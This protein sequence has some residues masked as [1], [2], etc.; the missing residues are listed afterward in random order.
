MALRLIVLTASEGEPASVLLKGRTAKIGRAVGCDVRLPDPSVSAHH[1]T[2]RRRGDNY[3]LIDEGSRH[4]TAASSSEAIERGQP[5]VWLAPESPRVLENNEHIWV[6]EIE[7]L[8]A[9]ET[10][11]RGANTGQEELPYELVRRGLKSAGIE[12]TDEM[13]SKT[14]AELTDL[15]EETL[16]QQLEEEVCQ[17]RERLGVAALEEDDRNPPWVADAMISSLAIL[18]LF[19]AAYGIFYLVSLR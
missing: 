18:I 5:L 10:T 17:S 9:F 15:P 6:G 7:L 13:V 4:G 2:I 3:I 11:K 14:L 19:G 16:H 8:V 1:A 12:A